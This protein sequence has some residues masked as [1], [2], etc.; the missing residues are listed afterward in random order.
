MG[1][2]RG[3]G[4]A[5]SQGRRT[6]ALECGPH[7]DMPSLCGGRG[8]SA[9]AGWVTVGCDKMKGAD[10]GKTEDGSSPMSLEEDD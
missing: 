6:P 5:I 8:D 4:G 9:R 2:G 10:V 7:V 3:K 1:R